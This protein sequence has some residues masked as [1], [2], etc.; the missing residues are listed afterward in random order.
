MSVAKS[1][2][3]GQAGLRA[4]WGVIIFATT[5]AFMLGATLLSLER[6]APALLRKINDP[7]GGFLSK[8][9]LLLII[10]QVAKIVLLLAATFLT[11][12][13]ERRSV[14]SYGLGGT[15]SLRNFTIGILC[16]FV[17]LSLLIGLL[18]VGKYIIFDGWA[19]QG[20]A[21]AGYAIFWAFDFLLVGFYEENQLR[22]YLQQTLAR[23]VGFWPAAIC[24]SVVFGL[25]HIGNSGE[26]LVGIAQVALA[27]LV[28]CAGLR[29]TGS[30]WW[31]IGFHTAWNWTQ[32]FVYG[33]L[34]S[35]LPAQGHLLS[36]HPTGDP[37]LSGGKVGPEGS[38][39]CIALLLVILALMVVMLNRR[40]SSSRRGA[41]AAECEG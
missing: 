22:G 21:I 18:A 30:L 37:R 11:A 28:L 14:W 16:G 3:V 32:S 29:L 31:S 5:F 7:S 23:G 25:T 4:G 34:N 38:L 13:I 35:G 1:I 9:S 10:V 27:G 17:S 26:T 39:V 41:I 33:T 12:K 36:S 24:T 19:A 8:P 6:L 2:F 15:R 20:D 40:S